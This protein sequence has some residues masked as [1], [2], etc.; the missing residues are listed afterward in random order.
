MICNPTAGDNLSTKV[1]NDSIVPDTYQV[2]QIQYS[3]NKPA[4]RLRTPLQL[5]S[6][7]DYTNSSIEARHEDPT[8]IVTGFHNSF[9]TL[10]TAQLRHILKPKTD[11]I[12][13]PTA[14]T[15]P[16]TNSLNR[17]GRPQQIHCYR[18]QSNYGCP[19]KHKQM[20]KYSSSRVLHATR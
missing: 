14:A 7:T 15:L 13:I 20:K 18:S 5:S 17:S 8:R 11:T 4:P 6:T 19:K 10:Q 16:N 9:I 3:T 1:T 2:T 12:S